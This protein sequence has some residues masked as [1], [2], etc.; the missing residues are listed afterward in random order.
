MEKR[1]IKT[2]ASPAGFNATALFMSHPE[3]NI[4]PV[5]EWPVRVYI[6]DTD[7]GGVVFYANY[8]KFF[9]RARTE[10][11]RSLGV[12]Q[13]ALMDEHSLAFVVSNMSVDYARSARLDDELRIT[14]KIGRIGKASIHFLQEIWREK[15]LLTSAQIQ[16]VSVS[17]PQMRPV[18]IPSGILA[19]MQ[20]KQ[21]RAFS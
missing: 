8:L 2:G 13:Q 9:E 19:R 21:G 7:M 16:I 10:W 4:F 18:A 11:L 12:T 5:F 6:E 14:V 17:L 20:N 1:Q 3:K 15:T